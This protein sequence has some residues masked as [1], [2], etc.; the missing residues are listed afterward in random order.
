VRRLFVVCAALAVLGMAPTPALASAVLDQ[1]NE[2][3]DTATNA[4]SSAANLAQTFTVGKMNR[5]GSDGGSVSWRMMEQCQRTKAVTTTVTATRR[6]F[7]S[8]PSG[9]SSR[10]SSS[11]ANAMEPLPA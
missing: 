9:W 2:P 1:S 7:E 3:V 4:F 5:T 6:S 8:A 10:R 11:P